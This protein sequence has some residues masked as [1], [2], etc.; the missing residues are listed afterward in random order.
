M[1]IFK[2]LLG[3]KLQTGDGDFEINDISYLSQQQF[4]K[5]QRGDHLCDYIQQSIFEEE[6]REFSEF[7]LLASF[8]ILK[9][10]EFMNFQ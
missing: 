3:E 6:Y 7:D 10:K 8:N 4:I 9:N 1:N 2:E 5:D